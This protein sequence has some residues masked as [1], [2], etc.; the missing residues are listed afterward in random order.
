ML[1]SHLE[2]RGGDNG[3]DLV[4]PAFFMIRD[5]QTGRVT[6]SCD[7]SIPTSIAV[8]DCTFADGTTREELTKTHPAPRESS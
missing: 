6:V 3:F 7:S 8:A 4:A 2:Q 1:A 5:S